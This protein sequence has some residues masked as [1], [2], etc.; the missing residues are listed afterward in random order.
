MDQQ[1]KYVDTDCMLLSDYEWKYLFLLVTIVVK[2][3][4]L[5]GTLNELLEVRINMREKWH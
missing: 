4:M 2:Y 3:L 1:W 5:V